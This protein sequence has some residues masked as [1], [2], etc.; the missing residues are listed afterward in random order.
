MRLS[1][2]PTQSDSDAGSIYGSIF[3]GEQYPVR[4]VPFE[5]KAS[6]N[7]DF[8]SPG[9]V[10]DSLPV[11]ISQSTS[12]QTESTSTPAAN[13]SSLG[14]VTASKSETETSSL[15]PSVET[16]APNDAASSNA[17]QTIGVNGKP[18]DGSTQTAQTATPFRPPVPVDNSFD[19]SAIDPMWWWLSLVPLVLVPLFLFRFVMG[20]SSSYELAKY[21]YR[22][23]T[24]SD[25]EASDV[26]GRFKKRSA[27]GNSNASSGA[28]AKQVDDA[29]DVVDPDDDLSFIDEI[30]EGVSMNFNAD[31]VSDSVAQVP[32]VE[33]PADQAAADVMLSNF[34]SESDPVNDHSD[35][36]V[37]F[38]FFADEED[39]SV[40]DGVESAGNSELKENFAE[41]ANEAS[42]QDQVEVNQLVNVASDDSDE[43]DFF[44]DDDDEDGLGKTLP[45]DEP[46]IATSSV[47]AENAEAAFTS[48]DPETAESEEVFAEAQQEDDSVEAAV[49][50]TAA[51]AAVAATSA[52]AATA[53]GG[54]W[55]KRLFGRRKAKKTAVAEDDIED[56]AIAATATQEVEE[57][58]VIL[59]DVSSLE[60]PT[61][62]EVSP[63]E[64]T[65]PVG[66]SPG[67]SGSFD[68]SDSSEAFSLD[69]DSSDG[70]FDDDSDADYQFDAE[71][72]PT[73]LRSGDEGHSEI[74]NDSFDEVDVVASTSSEL[75][76]EGELKQ[77]A[78][79]SV[80]SS[81]AI[82]EEFETVGHITGSDE[83]PLLEDQMLDELVEAESESIDS[84]DDHVISFANSGV[85]SEDSSAFDAHDQL[86]TSETVTNESAEQ[87]LAELKSRI[88][89]LESQNATLET[90]RSSL[91]SELDEANK[92][93]VAAQ[94][95][96]E[97][98]KRLAELEVQLSEAQQT[99]KQLE[100]KLAAEAAARQQAAD[101]AEKARLEIESAKA[102]ADKAMAEAAEFRAKAEEA[103]SARSNA[104]QTPVDAGVPGGS[105]LAAAGG[106][107][108]G[109]AMAGGATESD[110]S[111]DPFRLEPDQVKIMLKKLKSERKKRLQTRDYFLKADSKR[112][113]VAKTLKQVSGELENLK[114][115]FEKVTDS[116]SESVPKQFVA[117]LK[118]KL[119]A[120]EEALKKNRSSK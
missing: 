27:T 76:G 35:S 47:D 32:A 54:S 2:I 60:E 51:T 73:P 6:R 67:D 61:I 81:P 116:S 98:S 79:A 106:A 80:D 86:D 26:R 23:P 48:D 65:V 45:D 84:G 96:E 28:A 88:D 75:E 17:S 102:T 93:N 5:P 40:T 44:D 119:D 38:D 100:E 69:D 24:V 12:A 22:G 56:A 74:A 104:E 10:D 41:A 7:D 4:E 68:F 39:A 108:A 120:A 66:T 71:G 57:D 70:L 52:V 112:R 59:D 109:A 13:E 21:K 64:T 72:D 85:A 95:A 9:N 58:D 111:D 20:T 16:E 63:E 50:A 114:L 36:D 3:S 34:S 77:V 29:T 43:F 30:D 18:V 14:T 110:R 31:P 89:D 113:E 117:E 94:A 92:A 105:L 62:A 8:F 118:E 11:K 19:L 101:E 25:P 87:L 107:V 115:E 42:A 99:T 37:D 78:A 53:K 15:E 49:A 97:D 91:K 33:T 55:V 82:E 1:P 83:L 103:M 90:E 46:A